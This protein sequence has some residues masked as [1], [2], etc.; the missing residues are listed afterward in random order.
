MEA[1]ENTDFDE[2]TRSWIRTIL[3]SFYDLIIQYKNDKSKLSELSSNKSERE[4]MSRVLDNMHQPRLNNNSI[5]FVPRADQSHTML[6][7]WFFN[8]IYTNYRQYA[9]VWFAT[10]NTNNFINIPLM[11]FPQPESPTEGF[12]QQHV[13]TYNY[14][15]GAHT[16]VFTPEKALRQILLHW[17][18][19][20][21]QVASTK[22][23]TS[24]PLHEIESR[25]DSLLKR[26][27][28]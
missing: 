3:S 19:L 16:Y 9:V 4:T 27:P 23:Q 18:T 8:L 2:T 26:L 17:A 20:M 28:V 25:V 21:P 5:S 6:G 10:G 7:S 11:E 13:L 1:V 15:T 14:T 24:S 22:Q 12:Q